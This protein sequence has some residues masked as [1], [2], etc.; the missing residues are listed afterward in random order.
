MDDED[1]GVFLLRFFH[2]MHEIPLDLGV[3]FGRWNRDHFGLDSTVVFGNLLRPGVIG[4]QALPDRHG[5]HASN[6]ELLCA[7]KEGAPIHTAMYI[8]VEKVD[9]L[10][11]ILTCSLAFHVPCLLEIEIGFSRKPA[12]RH[13]GAPLA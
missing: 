13:K 5:G 9:K 10:L 8:D 1:A 4:T 3:A 12:C 6:G 2:G 11:R 7:F